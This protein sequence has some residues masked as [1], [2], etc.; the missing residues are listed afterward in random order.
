MR[1]LLF[2]LLVSLF[3]VIP[4]YALDLDG[5]STE[6]IQMTRQ[7]ISKLQPVI[8]ERDSEESLATLTFK[9]LD[10]PLTK[11]E[12][13][14]LKQFRNLSRKE[15]GIKIPWRG[16]STGENDLI[17]IKGQR[18]KDKVRVRKEGKLE[19]VI[20]DR[21][22]PPQYLPLTAYQKYFEMMAAMEK[23]IGKRLYVDS[24][25]R[26][27]AF[28]LY[29]FV[30]YL[31]NHGFSVKETVRYVTLPGYSEHGDPGHQAIDFI[32][33]DGINGDPHVEEF[34]CLPENLWLQEHAQD[35]GFVLS[36]P[37]D[38]PDGITYEPWHWRYDPKAAREVAKE[39]APKVKTNDR[40]K[41]GTCKN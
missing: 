30:Y 2:F 29:L 12:K 33:R 28:Q 1:K 41:G 4:A 21:T 20:V 39:K 10:A 25:Y 31:R 8:R 38:C 19:T 16:L 37:R 23:D 27:S 3:F 17:A 26:S 7:I 5:L 18:V 22:L 24:G 36:Y 9:D 40:L 6:D 35:F 13:K 14:F 11:Q 34:E 32:N 15:T